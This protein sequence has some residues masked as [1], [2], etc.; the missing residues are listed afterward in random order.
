[1]VHLVFFS[2]TDSLDGR[3]EGGV[4]EVL[5][6]TCLLA[7]KCPFPSWSE[8]VP[9]SRGGNPSNIPFCSYEPSQQFVH[10]DVL[11]IGDASP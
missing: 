11:L 6:F 7:E 4:L 1:M 2:S 9:V 8:A 3:L 10:N 5:Q